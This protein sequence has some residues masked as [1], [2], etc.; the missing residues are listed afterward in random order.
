MSGVVCGAG[1][2]IAASAGGS[3]A[4]EPDSGLGATRGVSFADGMMGL[5][6]RACTGGC[7]DSAG[8]SGTAS[9]GVAG[10][11][12]GVAGADVSALAS[13]SAVFSRCHR[14]GSVAAGSVMPASGDM[15]SLMCWVKAET[16]SARVLGSQSLSGVL[17]TAQA[18]GLS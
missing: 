12:S 6:G 18:L 4:G 17:R 1:A 5:V 3:G 8:A 10:T 7:V 14:L 2:V 9:A 16:S 15:T 11:A 13:P